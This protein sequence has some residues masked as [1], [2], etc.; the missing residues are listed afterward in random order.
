MSG[1]NGEKIAI[2]L[3]QSGAKEKVRKNNS[4]RHPTVVRRGMMEKEERAARRV[5]EA[6]L[7]ESQERFELFMRHLPGAAFMKDR[8]GCYRYVNVTWEK[9]TGR[10]ADHAIGRRDVQL[11]PG[12]AAMYEAN[13]TCVIEHNKAIQVFEDFP[14]SDG[15]HT[16]L[17]SKFPF[18]NR[19]DDGRWGKEFNSSGCPYP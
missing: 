7:A 9:V 2:D 10:T 18:P 11:W 17:V 1:P 15:V 16:Y 8:S 4:V 19:P 5:A 6:E 12:Q 3:L 14:Q 13:D